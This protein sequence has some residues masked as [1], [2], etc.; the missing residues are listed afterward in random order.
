MPVITDPLSKCCGQTVNCR[1]A[2][3]AS[4]RNAKRYLMWARPGIAFTSCFRIFLITEYIHFFISYFSDQ[5]R[6]LRGYNNKMFKIQISSLIITGVVDI[7]IRAT[8][9]FDAKPLLEKDRDAKATTYFCCDSSISRFGWEYMKLK[10]L[11]L[12]TSLNFLGNIPILGSDYLDWGLNNARSLDENFITSFATMWYAD[13]LLLFTS[14]ANFMVLYHCLK[15]IDDDDRHNVYP[16]RDFSKDSMKAACRGSGCPLFFFG[17]LEVLFGIAQ[18]VV[19]AQGD[20]GDDVRTNFIVAA[21]VLAAVMIGHQIY[22]TRGENR[23][24]QTTSAPVETLP[25]AKAA[26][27]AETAA[28]DNNG[29]AGGESDAMAN[30]AVAC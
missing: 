11:I 18:F 15:R 1:M 20:L 8:L 2:N 5:N 25:V 6:G 10:Y 14:L 30:M 16:N 29:A 3:E 23:V 9:W 26:V 12:A 13:I 28:I 27:V 21:V 19:I 22:Y 24:Q 7:V 4:L 17:T